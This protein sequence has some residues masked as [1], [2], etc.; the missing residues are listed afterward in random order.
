[1][2]KRAIIS[3]STGVLII[4]IASIIHFNH[5]NKKIEKMNVKYIHNQGETQ[6]TTYSATYKQPDG[7]D[8]Q[9]QIEKRLHEFDMSLSEY[10]PTSIISR[11]N[12][13]DTT[14]R[15]DKDFEDMFNM[16]QEVADK[17][18][19]AFDITVGPLVKA[20]GFAFGNNDHSKI[21]NPAEFLPFIGY[22]KIHIENHKLIKDDPRIIIDANG[23]AQGQSSDVIGKLLEDNGCKNYMIEIGGE[24]VCKGANPE[25]KKWRIGID[26]PV[27][28]TLSI[29]DDIQ[30]IIELN[31]GAVTTAGNYRKFHIINGK[32]YGHLINPHSGYPETTNLL[33]VTVLASKGIIADGYDSPFMLLGL[34]KSLEALKKIPGI[35]CYFIYVDKNGKNQVYYTSGFKKYLSK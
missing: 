23:I 9:P 10:V 35:E 27:D 14:V 19:G 25:G 8:L 2:K 13:N 32:K 12:R 20:W 31:D 18:D 26:K 7:I 3:I 34:E 33:S 15:T 29:K 24:V 11:I 5:E 30:Q 21:P 28:D 6:G 16:S 17:T 22:K 4:I 1:M